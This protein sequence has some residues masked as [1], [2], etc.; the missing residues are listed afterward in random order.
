MKN[1]LQLLCLGLFMMTLSSCDTYVNAGGYAGGR[2]GY[3]RGAPPPPYYADHA[4]HYNY[5]QPSYDTRP[6][7]VG[8]N[9]GVNTGGLLNLNSSTRIGGY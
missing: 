5:S 3:A 4:G 6:A 7:G 1:T 2:P 9:A 8:V